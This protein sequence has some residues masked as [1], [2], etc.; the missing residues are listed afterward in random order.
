MPIHVRSKRRSASVPLQQS[1][2]RSKQGDL[3]FG[4][5]RPASDR[6]QKPPGIS[7]CMIV[8]NE[9]RFLEQCLESAKDVVDEMIV[10]DT[11]STDRTVE[12]AKSYGAVVVERPWRDDFA[13]AR[14]QALELATKRWILVLDAD[15]E[16][17]P[18]SKPALMQ[19]KDVP[20]EHT[21]VWARINNK[22]DDYRGTGSMSHAL[23]R[24]FPNAQEIRYAG[25]IHE[26]PT[27]GG[28]RNGLKAVI[29]Q[30]SIVHHGYV[31]EIVH[32]REKGA[33]N[34][35][36]VRAAAAAEPDDPFHW[37][38]LGTTAFLVEDY[39][40]ARDALEKMR[41]MVGNERR[42]FMPNGLSV[43]A[44]TY[45]DKL[46]MPE[47]GERV[48]RH[49]LVITPNY[50]NAH[51]QL[52]KALVAQGR[53]DE[54]REAYLAAIDDR[55]H[56][57]HQF[58]LDDQV[59]IW[60][61][62]SELGSTYVLEKNDE[63]AIKW[64]EK[65]LKNAP[66]AEPLHINRARALERLGKF[67][68]AEKGYR[69]VYELH[70]SDDS[71]IEYVNFLLRRQREREALA[72]IEECYPSCVPSKAVPLLMAGAAV[73]KRMGSADDER[74]LLEAARLMPWSAEILDPLEALLHERGKDS[75]IASLIEREERESPVTASDFARRARRA[76]AAGRSAEGLEL[77]RGGLEKD[78]EQPLLRYAAAAAHAQLGEDDAAIEML[79][80]IGEAPPPLQVAIFTLKANLLRTRGRVDEGIDSIRRALEIDRGNEDAMRAALELS[81]CC[82]REQRFADAAAIA[83]FALQ[84]S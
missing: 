35:A 77:A 76:I 64:F 19:L 2:V 42:G 38:N 58:V 36:M 74:Y 45:C 49:A 21:A 12:I 44:E 70:R 15:E 33:R 61:A 80:A 8:K 16:L 28:D 57:S 67:D 75:E 60:K 3:P 79:N 20:A 68:E 47:E 39:E 13:W 1:A 14:N 31:K 32:Q 82:L 73:A 40:M 7:L 56:A 4:L 18:E 6:V 17:T 78:P 50:A 71:G 84:R 10:V 27:I 81:A 48:A 54:A 83:D 9:E 24:I 34:L 46:G 30:V 69:S 22:A 23:V 62:Q 51:F 65:G 72:V 55:N 63:K 37:F 59:Y 11:G 66:Q 43:L 5:P 25:L 53:L 41:A 52:G 29:A 26:F